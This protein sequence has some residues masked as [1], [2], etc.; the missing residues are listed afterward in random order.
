MGLRVTVV[1]IMLALLIIM[2]IFLDINYSNNNI[3]I[4][5]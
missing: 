1:R 5:Y 2:M 4:I 3:I